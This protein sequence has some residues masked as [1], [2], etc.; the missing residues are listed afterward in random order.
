MLRTVDRLRMPHFSGPVEEACD[1]YGWME[2]KYNTILV[3]LRCELL[4]SF[5][6]PAVSHL[7]DF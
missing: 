5:R 1:L 2:V 7:G 3:A 6:F 4:V